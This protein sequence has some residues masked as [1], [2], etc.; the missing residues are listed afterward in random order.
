[1]WRDDGVSF[2]ATVAVAAQA[3]SFATASTSTVIEAAADDARDYQPGD[4]PNLDRCRQWPAA[5][6]RRQT[7]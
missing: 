4:A 5:S 7:E 2:S 6:G 3:V 1:M